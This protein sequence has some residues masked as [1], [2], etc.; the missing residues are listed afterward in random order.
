MTTKEDVRAKVI[1]LLNDTR[2]MCEKN[3][4]SY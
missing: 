3:L 4:I 1:E 2:I